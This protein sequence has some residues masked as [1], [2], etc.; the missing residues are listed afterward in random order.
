MV[1]DPHTAPHP[2]AH[3]T[4]AYTYPTPQ[5]HPYTPH[6]PDTH[7]TSTPKHV[8]TNGDVEITD[9]HRD[10]D[11]LTMIAKL[12]YK[13]NRDGNI[14]ARIVRHV[15]AANRRLAKLSHKPHKTK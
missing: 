1:S 8:Y 3:S 11:A 12:A 9:F 10:D 14:D 2:L 4:P 6:T 7:V 15:E 13:S 5:E